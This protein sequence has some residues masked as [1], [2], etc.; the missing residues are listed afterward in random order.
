[1][2]WRKWLKNECGETDIVTMLVGVVLLLFL[3]LLLR[4]EL[5]SIVEY[6][7]TFISSLVG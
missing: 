1:M 2:M 7:R 4:R 6:L 3:L 5:F